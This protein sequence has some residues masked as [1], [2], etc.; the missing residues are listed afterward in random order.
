MSK[1]VM[2][3]CYNTLLHYESEEDRVGIWKKMKEAVEYI[4]GKKLSISIKELKVLY[5]AEYKKEEKQCISKRG[6][7]AEISLG[8]VWF[9]V[10]TNLGIP[11]KMAEEKAEDILLLHRLYA[12]KEKHL[13]P[14]VQEE[15]MALKEKG[16]KLLLLSNAQNCFIYNELPLEVRRL[17]D[18]VLISEEMGMK[19]P[20]KEVFQL[21][22][23]KLGMKPEDTVFVG[24]SAEDDMIPAGKAGC[25]C[26]MIGKE[27]RTDPALSHVIHFNPYKENGYAGLAEIVGRIFCS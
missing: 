27:K 6:I 8:R 14:N 5:D 25:H 24:D 15:L 20:A 11:Q 22:F 3:D 2:F 19:K 13:F 12:R 7:Y 18:V 17:F 1:A 4:T 21:A 9:Q 26:I 16:M 23:D 10:L